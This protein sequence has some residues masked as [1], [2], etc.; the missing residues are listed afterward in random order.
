MALGLRDLRLCPNRTA[1]EVYQA[2]VWRGVRTHHAAAAPIAGGMRP[3]PRRR[4][5]YTALLRQRQR[6]AALLQVRGAAAARQGGLERGVSIEPQTPQAKHTQRP[7]CTCT[8]KLRW[9][10]EPWKGQSARST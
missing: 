3:A 10:S 4:I 6:H 8:R 7:L 9:R 5:A 1:V 2:S